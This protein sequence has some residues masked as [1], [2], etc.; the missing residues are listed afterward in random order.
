MI[1]AIPLIP[2]LEI[3]RIN[4][5]VRANAQVV[6]VISNAAKGLFVTFDQQKAKVF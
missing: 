5:A 2:D 3:P 6:V 4:A 1:A